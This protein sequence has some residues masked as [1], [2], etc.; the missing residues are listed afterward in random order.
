VEED[1]VEAAGIL[2]DLRE[3]LDEVGGKF[4]DCPDPYGEDE[5]GLE[6]RIPPLEPE[7]D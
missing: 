2:D 4:P 3:A 5:E 6:F 7:D 1:L